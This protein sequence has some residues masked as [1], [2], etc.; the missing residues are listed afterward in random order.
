MTDE[1]LELIK[2]ITDLEHPELRRDKNID[3]IALMKQMILKDL[4]S[5]SDIIETLH[6]PD[7]EAKKAPPEDYHNVNIFSYLKIPDTQSIVKNFICFDIND[8]NEIYGASN[9]LERDVIFRAVSHEDDV[10][11]E[12]GINRQDL[13]GMLI[14]DRMSWT[15][16]MGMR[17]QKEYDAGKVAENGYYYRDIKYIIQAP[18]AMNQKHY[19]TQFD[20]ARGIYGQ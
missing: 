1:R 8:M 15:N 13:L 6:N 19:I 11:T 14:K 16:Y 4:Y 10:K 18:N 9:F 2:A 3:M 17:L 5:D 20:K 7:L 12:Y